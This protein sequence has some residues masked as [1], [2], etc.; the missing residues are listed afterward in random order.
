MTILL[1]MAGAAQLALFAVLA[2][3]ALFLTPF[4][5]AG[6]FSATHLTWAGIWVAA[7][8]FKPCGW[9]GR[10]LNSSSRNAWAGNAIANPA[11]QRATLN[12][13]LRDCIGRFP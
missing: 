13:E 7:D 11:A 2:L 5:T 10:E 4:F 9:P 1:D 12:D 3:A 6:V 8:L